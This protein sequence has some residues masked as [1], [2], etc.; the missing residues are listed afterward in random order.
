MVVHKSML[1]TL[2]NEDVYSVSDRFPELRHRLLD[3]AEDYQRVQAA[4]VA[5]QDVEN[6]STIKAKKVMT[7]RAAVANNQDPLAILK[8]QL[9]Q[10]DAKL[11]QMSG[12]KPNLRP[13]A[14]A[15]L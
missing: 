4:A 10:Q 8:A 5:A 9:S 2:S 12:V 14:T 15:R 11:E 7:G 6:L 3:H 13:Y 1:H